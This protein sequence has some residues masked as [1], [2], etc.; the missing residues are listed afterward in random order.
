M[1]ARKDH[2]AIWDDRQISAGADRH[3]AISAAIDQASVAVLLVSAEFLASDEICDV[4]VAR[5]LQRRKEAGLRVIPL[6]VKPCQWQ[7]TSWLQP[8]QPRP[9]GGIPLASMAQHR[10]DDALSVL[11][12]EIDRLLRM[13]QCNRHAAEGQEW[14]SDAEQPE[15]V[16]SS[17]TRELRC[18]RHGALL[19][20]GAGPVPIEALGA[21]HLVGKTGT[22]LL[23]WSDDVKRD[24]DLRV[25]R[26]GSGDVQLFYGQARIRL[27]GRLLSLDDVRCPSLV[28]P[29]SE[30]LPCTT[31]PMPSTYLSLLE[32][33]AQ[34][35]RVRRVWKVRLRG[36]D[37]EDLLPGTN[38][39]ASAPVSGVVVWPKTAS[40]S[41][42]AEVVG[43]NVE[44]ADEA[45]LVERHTDGSLLVGNFV[46]QPLLLSPSEGLAAFIAVRREGQ[47]HGA[48][49]I[50]ELTRTPP[51]ERPLTGLI[52]IDF[53]TANSAVMYASGADDQPHAVESGV[54]SAAE[55]CRLPSVGGSFLG[56]LVKES[57]AIFSGW[58][59]RLDSERGPLLPTLLVE[60]LSGKRRLHASVVPRDP[61]LVG[62]LLPTPQTRVHDNLKWQPLG[63]YAAEAVKTYLERIL[64]PAFHALDSQGVTTVRVAATYPPA[65]DR[66]RTARFKSCVSDVLQRL[67]EST[68][69]S[70]DSAVRYY[71]KCQASIA[72]AGMP[73][74]PY[75]L[76]ID[77]GASGTSLAVV[78]PKGIVAGSLD[79][80]QR[81]IL[82]ALTVDR[83][84]DD[85]RARLA[86]YV[87]GTTP[88]GEDACG[89][90]F[91]RLLQER[92]MSE[93]VAA[94]LPSD[95]LRSRQAMAAVLAAIVVAAN[96][97]LRCTLPS[98]AS[99]I[100]VAAYL[101]GRG[102]P[103]L[104]ARLTKG[105][106][107]AG[108]IKAL[109]SLSSRRYDIKNM[110]EPMRSVDR[111]LQCARWAIALLRDDVPAPGDNPR[112]VL[113]FD[114]E[115]KHGH[116]A[117]DKT[118]AEIGV[119]DLTGDAGLAPVIDELVNAM[120]LVCEG[121][122]IGDP[123]SRLRE[124][125]GP[126]KTYLDQLIDHG[127]QAIERSID[128]NIGL[129]CSPLTT[130]LSDPWVQFWTQ[131]HDPPSS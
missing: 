59:E 107:E 19:R 1:L 12:D 22:D 31:I 47:E 72:G 86:Q 14:S 109:Q 48:V 10:A 106:S 108:L 24:P 26:Q 63:E 13:W 34:W 60:R 112:H 126:S 49:Q 66:A 113:G 94:V 38:S 128:P 73:V 69:L 54:R 42:R 84:P 3:A 118:I 119:P 50:D 89:I 21:A 30:G 35:D 78:S 18:M 93:V 117:A 104:H 120:H 88:K 68:G 46:P 29:D 61:K 122:A 27:K 36:R 51:S 102:W 56:P 43:A 127:Y 103:V 17:D 55:H 8:I 80:T 20:N 65:F 7:K 85:V 123:W 15:L 130:F 23:I 97:L 105:F 58:H 44:L 40:S 9:N 131:V 83:R 2:L 71:S 124:R 37:R 114:L 87:R 75:T 67:C 92:D 11:A 32:G 28:V 45:A 6:I 90:L 4:Q 121:L 101:F 77:M 99:P 111:K 91:E 98:A 82:R 33:R 116:L 64:L 70:L 53:G 16:V 81:T 41:W 5:V 57:L 129:R 125:C 79:I 62:N 25:V 115:T 39:S 96:R 76:A 74:A 110:T 95:S 100:E 52:A